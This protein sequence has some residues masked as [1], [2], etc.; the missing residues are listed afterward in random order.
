VQELT[1]MDGQEIVE[2]YWKGLPRYQRT[3]VRQ[4]WQQEG[5]TLLP[6]MEVKK[7]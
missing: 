7:G 1:E 6:F 3:R 5:R 4:Q 2:E